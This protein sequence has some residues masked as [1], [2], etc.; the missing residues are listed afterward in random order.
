MKMD[1][2]HMSVIDDVLAEAPER[3]RE[4]QQQKRDAAATLLLAQ[5]NEE[6][7]GLRWELVP[8]P[9]GLRIIGYDHTDGGPR[10]YGHVRFHT[11][12]DTGV[13]LREYTATAVGMPSHRFT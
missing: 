10:A 8:N 5:V 11:R 12:S 13:R 6:Q 4:R 1:G 9:P 7:P 3:K 2:E